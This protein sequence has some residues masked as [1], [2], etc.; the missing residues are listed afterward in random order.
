[1]HTVTLS[2]KHQTSNNK[3]HSKKQETVTHQTVFIISLIILYV[4]RRLGVRV[5]RMRRDGTHCLR[6]HRRD[7]SVGWV[8]LTGG[9]QLL[10]GGRP[11]ST[12]CSTTRHLVLRS[13]RRRPCER[14]RPRHRPSLRAATR[15]HEAVA[16]KSART[17]LPFVERALPLGLIL[18]SDTEELG[19][20]VLHRPTAPDSDC[21]AVHEWRHTMVKQIV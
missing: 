12:G 3:L 11:G 8:K 9:E 18:V 21:S 17:R 13:R 19:N 20:T 7:S 16:L 5:K 10:W 14:R 2:K 1:M 4:H 6:R 15:Q